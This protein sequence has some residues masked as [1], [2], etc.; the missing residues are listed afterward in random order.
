MAAT[1]LGDRSAIA[2]ISNRSPSRSSR[3]RWT[4]WATAPRPRT[5]T[6]TRSKVL[7]ASIQAAPL[8]PLEPVAEALD[9]LAKLGLP[10]TRAIHDRGR[11]LRHER[12]VRQ[13]RLGRGQEPLGVGQLPRQPLALE[14]GRR[15][16]DRG[17]AEDCLDRPGDDRERAVAARRGERLRREASRDGTDAG[18]AL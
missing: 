1:R 3:G 10:G 18:E 14:G 5:P 9:L 8:S 11:G 2:L 13:A 6:L 7:R 15:R 17:L 4:A 12:L 16:I